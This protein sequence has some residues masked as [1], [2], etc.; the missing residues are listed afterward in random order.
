MTV[1]IKD[2]AREA[3]CSYA[4]VSRALNN[5]KDVSE[6]TRIH[7]QKLANEMGYRPNGI[8]RSLVMKRSN[9]IGLIV[10]DVSNPFFADL[11]RSVSMAANRAGYSTVIINTGWDAANEQ[12]QL[13]VLAGQ[14]VAG[15]IIKPTGYYASGT[16]QNIDVPIVAFWHPSDDAATYI[17]VDHKRGTQIAV[18]SLINRGFR[19]IA[20]IGG[21]D[22]SPANQL[23]LLSFQK[24]LQANGIMLHHH[25]VS[26]GGF[27]AESGYERTK[28]LMTG[29]NPP[30]GIFCGNDYIALGA[31]EYLKENNYKLPEEIGLIGYDDVFFSQ[32]PLISLSS[33][34]QPRDIMGQC[35]VDA[36]LEQIETEETLSEAKKILIEPELIIRST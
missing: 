22:T 24:T 15:I 12:N 30:D 8:A 21:T 3:G 1:T 17:E 31:L 5:K 14:R 23:R 28:A 13:R 20:F 36:I 34:R 25:L 11:A 16:Y 33:V 29:A 19:K 35:A 4:T 32:L 26:F 10:P 2:I 18:Q 6:R 7:I 27:N 9:V